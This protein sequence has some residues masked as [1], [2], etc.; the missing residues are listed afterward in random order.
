MITTIPLTI[1]TPCYQIER[2]SR[3]NYT[4]R[5]NI[6]GSKTVLTGIAAARFYD[7]VCRCSMVALDRVIQAY[8]VTP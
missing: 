4:L 5:R 2:D 1:F 8:E 7:E 3:N 6:D